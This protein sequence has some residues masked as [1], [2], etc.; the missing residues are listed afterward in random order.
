MKA[1]GFVIFLLLL[2]SLSFGGYIVYDKFIAKDT[3]EDCKTEEKKDKKEDVEEGKAVDLTEN[4]VSTLMIKINNLNT[5]LYSQYPITDVKSLENQL[6]LRTG[7][8]LLKDGIVTNSGIVGFSSNKLVEE[9]VSYFGSDY[10]YKLED[11]QCHAGDGVLYHYDTQTS[12]YKVTGTHG[13]DGGSYR[14]NKA[15]F[16]DGTYDEATGTYVIH[17]KV[18][19]AAEC[20]GT[21]GPRVEFYGDT[22]STEPV[23]TA[24]QDTEFDVAYQASVDKIPVTTYTFI[25]NSDGGFGLKSV[26]MQTNEA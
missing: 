8:V 11:I 21:C 23:Y 13:H 4:N 10:P 25:K 20:G 3:K 19:Y 24:Q 17:A 14:R 9:I 6:V 22:K 1:R 26:T 12:E 16:Q 18:L 2:A 15:Y 7:T 5:F